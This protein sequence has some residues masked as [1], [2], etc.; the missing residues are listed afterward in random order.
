MADLSSKSGWK[1]SFK[2]SVITN[3]RSA[4]MNWKLV[5]GLTLVAASQ[6]ALAGGSYIGMVKPEHYGSLYLNVS[7]TQMANRPACATRNY[8]H[9]Q[10]DPSETGYKSKFAMI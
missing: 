7:A 9:L 4:A 1:Q 2:V 8:V 3:T 5:M 6:A 10:K